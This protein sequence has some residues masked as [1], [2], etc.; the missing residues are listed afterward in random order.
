MN[1]SMRY[2]TR[3]HPSLSSRQAGCNL[4]VA[5][6]RLLRPLGCPDRPAQHD[7][8]HDSFS[9]NDVSIDGIP[10]RPRR[11]PAGVRCSLTACGT[12]ELYRN[13]PRAYP[14]R[15]GVL[16]LELD[17]EDME[18]TLTVWLCEDQP[19]AARRASKVIRRWGFDLGLEVQLWIACPDWADLRETALAADV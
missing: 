5:W 1:A 12:N 9:W 14:L 6:P 7:P 3:R 13:Y 17:T 15:D 10:A 11:R 8:D 2:Q 19:D 16:L 4:F 18:R